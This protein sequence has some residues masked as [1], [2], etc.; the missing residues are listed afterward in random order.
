MMMMMIMMTTIVIISHHKL[1]HSVLTSL[2]L[3]VFCFI[4]RWSRQH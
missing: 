1:L 4:S 3:P 2:I